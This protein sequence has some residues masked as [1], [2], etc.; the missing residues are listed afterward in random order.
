MEHGILNKSRNK[1]IVH[2][3]IRN[4]CGLTPTIMDES[5]FTSALEL[6]LNRLISDQ[7]THWY[8]EFKRFLSF[9][10]GKHAFPFIKTY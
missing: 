9:T 4:P 6:N 2:V 1:T 10:D 5:V 3:V 8:T 7:F